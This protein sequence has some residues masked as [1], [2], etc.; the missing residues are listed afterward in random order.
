MA[1]LKMLEEGLI[2]PEEADALLRAWALDISLPIYTGN[3]LICRKVLAWP[4]TSLLAQK[5]YRMVQPFDS[6]ATCGR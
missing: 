3:I 1:I 6:A 4:L 5:P 2:T